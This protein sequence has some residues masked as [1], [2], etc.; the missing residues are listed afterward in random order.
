MMSFHFCLIYHLTCLTL[1]EHLLRV[2]LMLGQVFHLNGVK[3]AQ[4]AVDGDKRKVNTM[5]LHALHQFT[6][7]M[8]S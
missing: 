3:T 7:E 4:A 5:N 2:H 6:T 8:Q 1:D